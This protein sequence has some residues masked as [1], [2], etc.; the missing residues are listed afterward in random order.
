MKNSQPN[1]IESRKRILKALTECAT[2]RNGVLS[3][4]AKELYTTRLSREPL[5]DVLLS[6]DKLGEAERGEYETAIP[7][8][9]GLLAL[10]KTV[11]IARLNRLEAEK[12]KRLVRWQCPECRVGSSAWV[13][14]N[15]SLEMRCHGIPKTRKVG[16]PGDAVPICGARM[17]VVFDEAVDCTEEELQPVD[18]TR[19]LS[20]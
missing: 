15:G 16:R 6:L 13:A 10:V 8:I 18:L 1:L 17:V 19:L 2:L 3:K 11:T 9:G 14:P 7:E 20:K 12:K 4:D 5:Q